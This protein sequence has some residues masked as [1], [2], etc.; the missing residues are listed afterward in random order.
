MPSDSASEITKVQRNWLGGL[1]HRG[2]RESQTFEAPVGRTDCKNYILIIVC[3]S[4][5]KEC[6]IGRYS[7]HAAE[8]AAP[9]YK[10]VHVLQ[11]TYQALRYVRNTADP[12]V[13]I[14]QHEYSLVDF[15]Y[16]LGEDDT[17]SS[18]ITNLSFI[19]QLNSRNRTAIFMH[20]MYLT[21]HGLNRINRQLFSANIPIFHT[22]REGCA[23]SQVNFTELGIP[24]FGV[25]KVPK[26]PRSFT[27]GAFGFLSPN[28][29]VRSTL[30]LCARAGV[31]I[32]ANYAPN[33]TG[34]PQ[35]I[36]DAQRHV[37]SQVKEMNLSGKVTFDFMSD[38]DLKD[39]ISETSV[40]Y[41]PQHD[42]AHYATSA[43]VRFPLAVG[44]GAIVPPYRCF[45][46]LAAGVRFAQ[47][48]DAVK[49]VTSMAA[50]PDEAQKLAEIGLN[51]AKEHEMGKIYKSLGERLI[52]N[53][54]WCGGDADGFRLPV[55]PADVQARM[56]SLDD[57]DPWSGQNENG[58][59]MTNRGLVGGFFV[60]KE[61][62]V[63]GGHT[64]DGRFQTLST[65]ID[66]KDSV[67]GIESVL[68]NYFGD[69][70]A[71]RNDL[72]HAF[73]GNVHFISVLELLGL[74]TYLKSLILNLKFDMSAEA[75]AIH[76][77][78]LRKLPGDSMMGLLFTSCEML[79][80]LSE[81]NIANT[82]SL[83]WGNA[84]LPGVDRIREI[85]YPES[86][87]SLQDENFIVGLYRSVLRRNPEQSG[88]D[89]L[90][91]L[92]ASGIKKSSITFSVAHSPEGREVD[93]Q[94]G[95]SLAEWLS[96][97]EEITSLVEMSKMVA[98]YAALI[99]SENLSARD[100]FYAK[101]IG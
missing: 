26:M 101:I 39:M 80:Q 82:E 67:E 69:E 71:S 91:H 14:F 50:N 62:A 36:A 34:S 66:A 29:D 21:D 90:Q 30:E 24:G 84:V 94:I 5:K 56:A 51:Y 63:P 49:I 37:E 12:C 87:L 4:S 10:D 89:N 35:A 100:K 27:V 23:K 93:V 13:V 85:I 60:Y 75:V 9:H 15:Q 20:S 18:V 72:G 32:R 61:N 22:N 95:G 92:L 73:G 16:D 74:P 19:Q 2:G 55:K 59:R 58:R 46:D 53:R 96:R 65:E 70:K 78:K 44:R 47:L 88:V 98:P 6:G 76:L 11:T 38:D 64:L 52:D 43:S 42:F 33:N 79:L 54:V 68:I 81:S 41:A 86:L 97:E 45:H 99:K 3:P 7:N 8:S 28:K 1:I 57:H 17:T 48:D 40:V 25:Q 77:H 31:Y 83:V